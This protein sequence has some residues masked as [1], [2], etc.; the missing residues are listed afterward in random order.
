MA[1]DVKALIEKA[2]KEVTENPA[3]LKQFKA[4]PVKALEK[5][6]GVDLPDDV[7]EQVVKAVQAKISAEKLADLVDDIDT[8]K[9]G[10]A[11]GALKKLF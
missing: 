1:L 6:L 4:E 10:D 11:L 3:L 9:L 7:I 5:V 8:Q 2:V